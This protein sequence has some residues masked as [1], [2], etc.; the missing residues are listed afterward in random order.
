MSTNEKDYPLWDKYLEG[1]NNALAAIYN[2]LFPELYIIAYRFFGSEYF[3]ADA[4]QEVF[5]KL[6]E[7]GER[8]REQ[9]KHMRLKISNINRYIQGILYNHIKSSL[10]KEIRRRDILQELYP[11][12]P[13]TF[14]RESPNL[15]DKISLGEITEFISQ[16]KND[17]YRTI[18]EYTL[19]GYNTS[20]IAEELGSTTKAVF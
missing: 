1:D 10:R 20:E 16:I 13:S 18:M 14:Q 17:N 8:E 7:I 6:I 11:W 5:I 12:D 3:A 19:N 9:D 4:V 15:G 2:Q